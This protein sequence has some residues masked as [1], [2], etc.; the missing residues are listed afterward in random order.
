MKEVWCWFYCS[1][2][3]QKSGR[4][5]RFNRA[6]QTKK[7]FYQF[8]LLMF[9]QQCY[10][11]G[12]WNALAFLDFV[13][14]GGGGRVEQQHVLLETP[15]LALSGTD[16]QGKAI[17]MHVHLLMGQL[18]CVFLHMPFA[19]SRWTSQVYLKIL[20][21]CTL[22]FFK[23]VGGAQDIHVAFTQL[24][25]KRNTHWFSASREKRG[26]CT[27]QKKVTHA[28]PTQKQ[29]FVGTSSSTASGKVGSILTA[30][31]V[32]HRTVTACVCQCCASGKT[33]DNIILA[34]VKDINNILVLGTATKQIGC[35]VIYLGI[36]FTCYL[37]ICSF[38]IASLLTF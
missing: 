29:W 6:I 17:C 35:Y 36:F 33:R 18:M 31:A 19:V 28:G 12:L 23:R 5:E 14:F 13:H 4:K 22:I 1:V 32:V 25:S 20:I 3:R 16:H 38:L 9:W 30:T 15:L 10:Q 11:C 24:C 21:F 26:Q 8:F 37:L 34:K 2:S 27:R 7:L